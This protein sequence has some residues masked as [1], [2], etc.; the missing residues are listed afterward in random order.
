L[1]KLVH[2]RDITIRTYDRGEGRVLVEGRLRDERHRPRSGE[3]FGGT[4]LVHDMVARLT[5][6]GPEMVIE[7]MEAEMPHHPREGCTEVLPWMQRLVGIRIASGFTQRVKELVGN[8][9]GCAHLT[10]L[11]L[12]L[13]PAAVQGFWAA[14]GVGREDLRAD[15][16]RIKMVVNTC[17]LWREDGP[18]IEDLRRAHKDD[19]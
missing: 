3:D 17:Y 11:L 10:S 19:S 12:T 4:F 15:D 5:V 2:G 1:K 13:G 6:R 9:R 8:S 14:Y 18:L 7:S 16:P